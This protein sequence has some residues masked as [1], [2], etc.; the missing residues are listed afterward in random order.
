MEVLVLKGNKS[1]YVFSKIKHFEALSYDQFNM[2][3]QGTLWDDQPNIF[4]MTD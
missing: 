1:K 2:T 3:D 4:K